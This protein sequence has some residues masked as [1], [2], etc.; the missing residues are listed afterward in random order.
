MLIEL[1]KEANK[2]NGL[3]AG[4]PPS[5]DFVADSRS[6]GQPNQFV[7]CMYLQSPSAVSLVLCLCTLFERSHGIC[8]RQPFY[9]DIEASISLYCCTSIIIYSSD[10]AANGGHF[11]NVMYKEVSWYAGRLGG[12]G[13]H[14]KLYLLIG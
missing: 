11:T 8:L 5:T 3:T 10:L 6:N 4:T 12:A 7:S 14:S 2:L 13:I 9:L 1:F